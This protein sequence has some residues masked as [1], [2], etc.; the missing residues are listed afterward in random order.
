MKTRLTFAIAL[1]CCA[2]ILAS[3]SH[4]QNGAY[5]SPALGALPAGITAS[6]NALNV[7][8]TGTG[9]LTIGSAGAFSGSITIIGVGS[10]ANLNAGSSAL[11]NNTLTWSGPGAAFGGLGPTGSINLTG[12]GACA[13][14]TGP[15]GGNWNGG[16]TCTGTTGASTLT[17]TPG[18]TATHFWNC[19]GADRT[20]VIAGVQSSLSA[21]SCTLN[22]SSV[23]SNDIVVITAWAF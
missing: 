14:I 11:G 13:T 7:G 19:N 18:I 9:T 22:F 2:V 21:T 20:A 8:T 15:T 3:L 23:T 5:N 4:A 17:I 12:T 10:G 16:G 1:I 6:P